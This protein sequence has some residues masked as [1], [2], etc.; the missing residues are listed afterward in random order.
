MPAG[1]LLLCDHPD[2]GTGLLPPGAPAL[3]ATDTAALDAAGATL[4]QGLGGP[5]RLWTTRLDDGTDDRPFWALVAITSHAPVSQFDLLHALAPQVLAAGPVACLALD[6]DGFHGHHDRAWAAAPGNLHLSVALPTR[7]SAATA[8]ASLS[9]LPAVAVCDAVATVTGGAV[10]PAIKWVNDIMV[11]AGKLAG[12]LTRTR[13]LG[14]AIDLAVFGA[15]VNLATAPAIPPTP[16]VPATAC[17]RECPGAEGV[18]LGALAW[19]TLDAFAARLGHLTLHGPGPLAEDYRRVSLVLGRHVRIWDDRATSGVN[20]QDWP[21][22]LAEGVVTAIG[23]DLSLTV[24]GRRETVHQGRLVLGE[25][26]PIPPP[27]V[28]R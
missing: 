26:P 13:V 4:W 7:L 24:D 15:G 12:V 11:P 3:R 14:R 16:F 1:V 2:P 6:G 25:R 21:P 9:M 5:P 23:D 20:S 22:P 17:L 27:A 8:G 18:T 10:R 28:A 19:A